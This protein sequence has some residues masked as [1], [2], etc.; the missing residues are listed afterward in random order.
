MEVAKA[1]TT[2]EFKIRVDQEMNDLEHINKK[3]IDCHREL[4]QN[5]C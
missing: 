1:K 4:K 3:R 5:S 2:N